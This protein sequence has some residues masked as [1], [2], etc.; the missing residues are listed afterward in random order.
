MGI[1]AVVLFFVVLCPWVI[2]PAGHQ[3]ILLQFGAVK[4]TLDEGIHFRVPLIQRVYKM[5]VRVQKEQAQAD[6]ASK[7]L[8]TVTS[9]IALNFHVNPSSAAHLYEQVGKDYGATII[10]PAIQEAVKAVTAKFTAE[11]LISQRRIVSS[12][13]KTL[14]ESK[15]RPY[16]IYVDGFNVVNFDFS[17]KFNEAVEE[18]L[19]AEQRALKA[20]RDLERIKI[21]AEQKVASAKAEAEALRIQKEQV[22]AELVRLR[23]IEVQKQAVE[24]WDGRLPNVTGG[25]VPFIQVSPNKE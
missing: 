21:E 12:D 3:G 7:D 8:Q 13:I 15:I 19:A 16:G 24:K 17:A 1:A 10:E 14:L 9:V 25:T 4:A 6:A 20:K 22:T 23:E 11:E 5:D 2:V 18:K